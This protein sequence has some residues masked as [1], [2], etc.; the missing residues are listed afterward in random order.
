MI[1]T[2]L[3][4]VVLTAR[5][6]ARVERRAALLMLPYA[7]WVAYATYLISGSGG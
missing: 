4:L 2:L 7:A 1:L 3:V 6:F 5:A